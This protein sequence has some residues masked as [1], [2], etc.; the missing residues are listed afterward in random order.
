MSSSCSPQRKSPLSPPPAERVV[1][2]ATV[3]Q[4]E[5]VVPGDDVVPRPAPHL[6]VTA[7]ARHLVVP[8]LGQAVVQGVGEGGAG[9]PASPAGCYRPARRRS[10]EPGRG[11]G[12]R[13]SGDAPSRG[14]RGGVNTAEDLPEIEGIP[15]IPSISGWSRRRKPAKT[16]PRSRGSPPSPRSRVGPLAPDLALQ[17]APPGHAAPRARSAPLW[18]P[19]TARH[20]GRPPPQRNPTSPPPPPPPT[21]PSPG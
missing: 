1:V 12:L 20:I 16:Y 21:T 19:G 3:Q 2:I 14:A 11:A 4:V 13:P 15:P 10:R 8:C 17:R 6:V 7:A 5:A 9:A 18:G